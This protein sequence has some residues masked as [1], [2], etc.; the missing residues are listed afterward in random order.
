MNLASRT[1]PGLLVG[2]VVIGGVLAW[3]VETWLVTSGR[4]VMAPPL[5]MPLTLVVLAALLLWLAWPIRAYTRRLWRERREAESRRRAPGLERGGAGGGADRHERH[6]RE[7]ERDVRGK[8]VDPQYAFRV[9][10]FARAASLASSLMAGVALGVLAFAVT[11]TVP[12]EEP[13]WHAVVSVIG[14]AVLLAV[15]LIAESWCRIPP[16]G[17][18]TATS[19]NPVAA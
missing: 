13:I 14:A 17:E 11:R 4:P 2:L 5:T 3:C 19:Q 7:V 6:G 16:G 8:R 12:P 1:R 10:A 18:E 9:L 15:G